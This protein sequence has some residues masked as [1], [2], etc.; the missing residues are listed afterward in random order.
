MAEYTESWL[1]LEEALGSRPGLSG[2]T[3]ELRTAYNSLTAALATQYPPA[4]SHVTAEDGTLGSGDAYR[5]YAPAKLSSPDGSVAIYFHSGGFALG[6]LDSED[7]LCR[8]LAEAGGI[9]LVSIGYRLAPEHKAL[10]QVDDGME[11][12]EWAAAN[13]ARLEGQSSLEKLRLLVIGVSAGGELALPVT[14]RVVLDAFPALGAG[15]YTSDR[16]YPPTCIAVCEN[17]PLRDDGRVVA[18]QLTAGGVRV[19]SKVYKGPPHCFWIFPTL[20]ETA[21]FVQDTVEGIQWV[22]NGDKP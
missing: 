9:V 16:N 2:S 22:L 18:G 10:A 7:Q 12:L 5:V 4:S 19:K 15:S 20:P 6:D 11:G 3:D 17:D 8:M 1:K 21:G 13:A 14:R